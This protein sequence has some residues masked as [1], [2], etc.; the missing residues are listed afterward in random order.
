MIRRR[1]PQGFKLVVV[2]LAL[3]IYVGIASATAKTITVGPSGCDNTSIQEATEA[4]SPGD[5]IEVKAGT[6]REN[7]TIEKS[8]TLKGA[9]RDQTEIKGKEEGKPVIMIESDQVIEVTIDG[10]TIAEAKVGTER[11]GK[12]DGIRVKGKAKA[13]IRACTVSENGD[14]GLS[15]DGSANV[16]VYDNLFLENTGGGIKVYSSEAKISGTPNEMRGNGADLCGYVPAS[17]RKPLVPQTDKAQLNVPGDYATVQEAIDAVAP[18]GTI[19]IAPGTYEGGMTIWKSLTLK[20]AGREQTILKALPERGLVVSIL[21]G[22]DVRLE[23]LGVIG[24]KVWGLLI[25]GNAALQNCTISDNQGKGIA[26]RGSS[27]VTLE[28]NI[29]TRNTREGVWVGDSAQAEIINNQITDNKAVSGKL[30]D[31]IEIVDNGRATI[32]DNTITGNDRLG[33][34]LWDAAQ[35]T[36]TNNTIAHNSSDGINIG[37]DKTRNETVQAEISGNRIQHNRGCGVD[38]D[39]DRGIK[40]TGR[41][42]TISGNRGENLCGD[43][44]KFPHGFGGG[45]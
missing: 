18:G 26:V 45:R 39:D 24:S 35:A 11:T 32:R 31:G 19:T 5:T 34:G 44:S 20:G 8:L 43:L 29:I 12:E 42:N 7:L 10:L 21:A 2:V 1:F 28:G 14:D 17:L 4:A 30:G 22:V 16:E 38:T 41:G 13:T 25:Y 33:V 15:I 36:I 3:V 6:Y 23:R 40:I 27:H 37:Y 9:G